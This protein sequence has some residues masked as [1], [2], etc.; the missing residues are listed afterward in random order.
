[1]TYE[2]LIKM[3]LDWTDGA[4]DTLKESD[5][6]AACLDAGYSYKNLV[7]NALAVNN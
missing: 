1:M 6:I 7:R 3:Y 5:V 2:E 4:D